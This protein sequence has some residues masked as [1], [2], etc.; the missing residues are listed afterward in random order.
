M[1]R[2]T[3]RSFEGKRAQT[4]VK[5]RITAAYDRAVGG[6]ATF[7]EADAEAHALIDEALP[8]VERAGRPRALA[9]AWSVKFCVE[10]RLKS[11]AMREAGMKAVRL[12]EAVGADRAALVVS[13]NLVEA[14]LET[15][16]I[17]SAISDG[18]ALVAR[19]RETYHT[20][21]LGFAL[22]MVSSALSLRG[23]VDAALAAAQ[24]AVP[25][26]RD[27]GMLFWFFDHMALR[28]A[29]AGHVQDAALLS[30]Y[31]DCVFRKFGRPREPVG[32]E[33]ISRLSDILRASLSGDEIELSRTIGEHLSEDRA[34][35]I[36]LRTQAN[37]S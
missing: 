15:G 11:P 30:G 29:I 23:D 13:A 6:E 16:D 37:G 21:V 33:A 28:L 24:D 10:A 2:P 4:D 12:C 17:D 31:A 8:M 3:D 5:R 18:Q 20:D 7:A 9:A 32:Q 25:L 35:A 26:L 34:I 14:V 19:L 36:A 1:Y 22:G 27:E